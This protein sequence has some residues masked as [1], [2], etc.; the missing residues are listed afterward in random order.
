[1]RRHT[2]SASPIGTGKAAP[3]WAQHNEPPSLPQLTLEQGGCKFLELPFKKN[4]SELSE[5]LW[6]YFGRFLPRPEVVGQEGLPADRSDDGVCPI[7]LRKAAENA[8][9]LR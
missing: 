1:M 6:H 2:A 3:G 4:H 9:G 5:A 8:L 7:T